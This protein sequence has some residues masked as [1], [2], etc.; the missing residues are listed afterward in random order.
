M[1][2]NEMN[3]LMPVATTNC[4]GGYSM[5]SWL[6]HQSAGNVTFEYNYCHD[7]STKCTQIYAQG[8]PT[9]VTYKYNYSVNFGMNA[10]GTCDHGEETQ[11][12]A[13]S[14]N[15]EFGFNTIITQL[16]PV[17]AS[18]ALTANESIGDPQCCST[19]G[20]TFNGFNMH[21]NIMID[22]GTASD[23]IAAYV[24][25]F[26]GGCSGST[27]DPAG[28]HNQWNNN[29]L[30]P[31]G[32]Y[33]P[34]YPSNGPG[35][36]TGFGGTDSFSSVTGNTNLNTGNSCEPSYFQDGGGVVSGSCN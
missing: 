25:S 24:V 12:W 29:Y 28:V 16:W 32:G 8:I 21:N 10:C 27:C 19:D 6:R 17:H 22:E 11:Y 33:Y 34:Y 36:A 9:T 30:D 2:Y 31:S 35:G 3:G 7:V 18:G 1:I 15:G 13:Q 14:I 4:C 26:G 5:E 23:L 20:P